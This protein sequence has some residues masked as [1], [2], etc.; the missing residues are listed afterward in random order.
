MIEE[1]RGEPFTVGHTSLIEILN[2]L[3]NGFCCK[4]NDEVII[5]IYSLQSRPI[6]I[7]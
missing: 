4:K 3:I 5:E 7:V 2:V 6:E 1:D